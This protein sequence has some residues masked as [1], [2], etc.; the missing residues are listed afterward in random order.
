MGALISMVEVLEETIGLFCV[1]QTQPQDEENKI[2]VSNLL[3]LA[4]RSYGRSVFHL[5]EFSVLCLSHNPQGIIDFFDAERSDVVMNPVH[6][7]TP[8]HDNR[9]SEVTRVGTS[10]SLFH[11]LR[12][13]R[14]R[15]IRK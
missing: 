2:T 4:K 1:N 9:R 6:C 8:T 12:F 3:H 10:D 11:I 5:L 13:L 14:I 15:K 7:R